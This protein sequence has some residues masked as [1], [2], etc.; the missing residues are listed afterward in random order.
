MK[1]QLFEG[2]GIE[3]E[4]MIVDRDDLSVKPICDQVLE[5]LAGEIVNEVSLGRINVSNE[6]VLHVIEFK[7][8][9]PQADLLR[10]RRSFQEQIRRVNDLLQRW[11]AQLLPTAMHPLMQPSQ[12]TKLWPHGQNAIYESYNRIFDCRGHGWSNLQSIHINLPFSGDAQ[13][14]PLHA[15]IRLVL[16]LLPG[17]AASSPLVE[18]RLTGM[19]DSR[20]NFYS[21]NQKRIASIIGQVIPERVFTEA[22]YEKTIFAAI[23]RDIAPHDPE[24]IL[25]EEWLNSRGAI[26]RFERDAI[27]IRLLDIQESVT[28]DFAVISLVSSLVKSLVDEFWSNYAAQQEFDEVELKQVFLG[29]VEKGGAYRLEHPQLLALFRLNA[30]CTLQD[31]WLHI[32]E[33]LGGA[34]SAY[35][36]KDFADEA[37]EILQKGT[38]SARLRQKL[39]AAPSREEIVAVYRELAQCLYEGRLYA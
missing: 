30:S 23:K 10:M 12:E 4:Y 35:V 2:Y 7:C 6:L 32:C 5:A 37:R 24:G 36:L 9:G 15:A 33:S 1:L 34:S 31:L 11:N 22:Q 19:A 26:A 38:L 21:Q 14:G 16:P 25:E 20:L 17:L 27:E 8:N 29:A 39:G 28:A 13:F 3:L 18:G